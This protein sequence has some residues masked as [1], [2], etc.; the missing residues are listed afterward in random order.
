MSSLYN[1]ILGAM[2]GGRTKT[3]CRLAI[4]QD[5][6][7]KRDANPGKWWLALDLAKAINFRSAVA[8][9]R[10]VHPTHFGAKTVKLHGNICTAAGDAHLVFEAASAGK[11]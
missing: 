11:M 2:Q 5:F 6:Y 7:G 8:H 10:F 3:P 1:K 9:D 4:D